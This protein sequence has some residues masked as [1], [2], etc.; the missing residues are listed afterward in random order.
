MSF[1]F[2]NKLVKYS[3]PVETLPDDELSLHDDM[4][5]CLAEKHF[6]E[7]ACYFLNVAE[8]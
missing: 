8:L 6:D 2:Q 3:H 5:Q 1:N 7:W 4:K